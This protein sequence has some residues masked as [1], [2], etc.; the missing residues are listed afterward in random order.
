MQNIEEKFKVIKPEIVEIVTRYIDI[1]ETEIPSTDYNIIN[2]CNEIK[3][4]CEEMNKINEDLN[5]IKHN[6]DST[7]SFFSLD[8]CYVYIKNKC[9]KIFDI[10]NDILNKS[11]IDSSKCLELINI[12][13]HNI[14]STAFMMKISII[15]KAN[16]NI[17]DKMLFIARL[18]LIKDN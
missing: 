7:N 17:P 14:N 18:T 16:K 13:K 5:C 3:I 9:S 2:D 8:E 10:Y 1:S 6:E 12:L 4:I 15:S 11:E